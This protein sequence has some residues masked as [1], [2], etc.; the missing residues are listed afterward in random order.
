LSTKKTRRTKN[1][2]ELF[3]AYA[4][5]SALTWHLDRPFDIAPRGGREYDVAA[6]AGLVAD[7]SGRLQ[8]A[9]LR[10]GERLAII[11]KN[12][13]DT[14]LLAAAAARIGALP[15]MVSDSIA[16]PVLATMMER[17]QPKVLVASD[18]VLAAAAAEGVKLT[19]GQTRVVAIDGDTSHVPGSVALEELGGAAVPPMD[20]RRNDE[21]MIC[22]HTS[23]TTGVPKLVAH[24]ANTLI[25]VLTKLETMP[26]PGLAVS[27]DDTFASCISFAHGRAIT[28]TFA[29]LARPPRKVVVIGDSEPRRVAELLSHHRPTVVEACP[30]I[31]QRWES[32]TR[33]TP[34]AF[35]SVRAYLNTFDAI[36]PSTVRKFLEV[37]ERRR[38]VWGQVWGQSETGPVAMAIYSRNKIRKNADALSPVTNN[39]GRPIPFVTRVRVADP[40]TR[41]PRPAGER[42]I[43][44]VRTRGLCLTYLGEDERFREKDW[45]G[46]WNTGDMGV[47]SRTGALR[48]LDREVDLVPGTSSIELESILLER[49]PQATEVIVLGNPGGL[50]LPVLS[51]S[52]DGLSDEEWGAATAGL[53]E[54]GKPRIIGWDEFPRTGTWK[55]RRHDLRQRL[56]GSQATHGTGRW[57]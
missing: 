37:S 13:H 11:K 22:T 49:L 52:N 12:H 16:S 39:V 50:P 56:L 35:R 30:N 27:R 18:S 5:D 55:V 46:W 54:L 15:A 53:P 42:G 48:I 6:L 28:W 51:L 9:G 7:M 31:Y 36:H 25:G 26:I 45:D 38:P 3:E 34:E 17:Y 32:V 41:E 8:E 2:G 43:V 24:S 47:R 10:R 4:G 40:D 14:V 21:L 1:L 23:G 33:E 29:Q 44:L 19:T 57:T 20:L